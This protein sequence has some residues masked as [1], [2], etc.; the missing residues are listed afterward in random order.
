MP[1]TSKKLKSNVLAKK[2]GVK[3]PKKDAVSTSVAKQLIQHQKAKKLR[4]MPKSNR[5]NLLPE[6]EAS[7][8][9]QLPQKS[10]KSVMDIFKRSFE[11]QFGKV[12]GLPESESEEEDSGETYDNDSEDSE[13]REDGEE[14]ENDSD[15]DLEMMEEYEHYQGQEDS[16]ESDPESEDEKPVVVRHTDSSFTVTATKQEK[17]LFMSSKAPLQEAKAELSS[18]RQ[19]TEEREEDEQLNLDNDLALQRLIKESHILAEAGL[20]GVDISTG[21]TGKA[22]HK[23]LESRLDDLGVK[24][25]KTQ[26]MPMNMRKGMTA[27]QKERHERHVK[28][29]R[30]AGIV[31]ARSEVS[32]AP[33][34]QVKRERG[35]KIASVGRETRHG[36]IISKSEISKYSGTGGG[37]KKGRR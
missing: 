7:E 12:E 37:K 36:L 22:R 9:E 5:P 24:R 19:R 28:N 27:K 10:D 2:A 23:T 18:K 4:N 34:K 17:K 8:D 20:S 13:E 26:Q 31:L 3:K 1:I 15:L 35:L 32:K 14:R 25:A 30:E 21:I 16:E 29:S 6:S 33:K 11:Q